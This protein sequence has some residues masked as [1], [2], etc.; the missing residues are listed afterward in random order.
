M[1]LQ[2]PEDNYLDLRFELYEL[3]MRMYQNE[4]KLRN[5]H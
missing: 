3:R 5:K 1:A 2:E 4:I